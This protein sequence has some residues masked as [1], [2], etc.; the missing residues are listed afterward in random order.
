MFPTHDPTTQQLIEAGFLLVLPSYQQFI[1]GLSKV[2]DF[3][4]FPC[5]YYALHM[6][7]YTY[8]YTYVYCRYVSQISNWY[9]PDSVML[10]RN[11]Y[12]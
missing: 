5:Y 6:S 12:E 1:K 4:V 11:L 7:I 8:I 3:K 10:T 2:I 9:T